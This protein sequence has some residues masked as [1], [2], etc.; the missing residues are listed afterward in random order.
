MKAY[1]GS[2]M[3]EGTVSE[4]SQFIAQRNT[5]SVVKLDMRKNSSYP[6]GVRPWKVG[7]KGHNKGWRKHG[8][9]SSE[10]MKMIGL[11]E[12]TTFAD[13]KPGSIEQKNYWR[14]CEYLRGKVKTLNLIK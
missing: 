3:V 11:P 12:T 8:S 14:A 10:A 7:S 9:R 2:I 1:I 13:L 6:N 4:I 5:T